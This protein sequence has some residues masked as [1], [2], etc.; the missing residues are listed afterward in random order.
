MRSEEEG[1]ETVDDVVKL[2]EHPSLKPPRTYRR[3][4]PRDTSSNFTKYALLE[5]ARLSSRTR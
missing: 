5:Y 1:D 2:S 4:T 3:K